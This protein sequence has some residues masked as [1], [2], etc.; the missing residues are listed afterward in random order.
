MMGVPIL[1]INKF[2]WTESSLF[3]S[4]KSWSFRLPIL[5]TKDPD[6]EDLFKRTS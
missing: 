3:F 4:N 2:V 6:T 5:K 1:K